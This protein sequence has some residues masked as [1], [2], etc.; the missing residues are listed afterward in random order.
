ML[1]RIT[2]ADKLLWVATNTLYPK[3]KHMKYRIL[4]YL[5]GLE[6]F[7]KKII[8]IALFIIFTW[9]G[10][11][12]FFTYEAD[13]IVPFVANSPFMSFFYNHP[14]DYKRH[15]NKEGEY[16]EANHQWHK[17]NNTY[18]FSRGLGVCL[19]LV[20][21][22]VILHPIAPLTSTIGSALMI[23]LTLGTLSFLIT[24]PECWVPNINDEVWGFPF[25]SARGRLVIKDLAILGGAV[26]SM[27]D[28]AALYLKRKGQLPPDREISRFG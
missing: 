3:L 18:G 7:G 17:G 5:A 14:G 28:S 24:T 19:V 12:K 15:L 2:S 10:I 11:L 21:V 22:M 26:V 16:I 9:I 8:R 20:G 27:S 1:K 23:L 6:A 25:L 4:F 13:G